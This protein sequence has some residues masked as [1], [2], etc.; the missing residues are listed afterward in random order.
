[1]ESFES[2]SLLL[3]LLHLLD[4]TDLWLG[5]NNLHVDR[6]VLAFE[7]LFLTLVPRLFG[8]H[9]ALR[10]IMLILSSADGRQ[11]AHQ[12]EVFSLDL[13]VSLHLTARKATFAESTPD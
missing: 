11:A 9:G 10:A 6:E 4:S 2:E 1:M 5:V 13:D 12:I 8:H 3:T 7:L